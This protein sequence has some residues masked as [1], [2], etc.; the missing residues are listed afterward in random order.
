MQEGC[1]EILKGHAGFKLHALPLQDLVHIRL[2]RF[3]S[4]LTHGLDDGSADQLFGCRADHLC[5]SAAD[6]QVAQVATA[7]C[8]HERGA[9][10]DLAL[11]CLLFDPIMDVGQHAMPGGDRPEFILGG[12]GACLEPAISTI[13][14][15]EANFH[16]SLRPGSL[17]G[18]HL[19]EEIRR[20]LRVQLQVHPAGCAFLPGDT[21]EFIPA[22]VD[23]EQPSIWRRCP[24]DGWYCIGQDAETLLEVVQP[25]FDLGALN[26]G[27]HP[28]GSL[29]HQR[30]FR[31]LPGPRLRLLDQQG[32]NHP[33]IPGKGHDHLGLDGKIHKL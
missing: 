8:Q 22:V 19:T 31:I 30:D 23:I 20:I 27:L 1:I 4:L 11:L 3:Q 25:A 15:L 14:P 9:V 10:N 17:D 16:H 5:I 6:E 18:L 12:N 29:L 28:F 13:M 7:A 2:D 32:C 21:G 24:Y 26:S 33:A